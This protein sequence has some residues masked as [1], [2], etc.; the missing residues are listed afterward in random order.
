MNSE[1]I[2]RIWIDL[3][4]SP[5]VPLFKPIIE[6]LH[7]QGYETI[8]TARDFAQTKQLLNLYK[9][10][11]KII[12]KHGGKNKIKKVLNLILRALQLYFYMF[13]KK[14]DIALSHGSRSQLVATKILFIKSVLMLDYEY[15]EHI[16]FNNLATILL[17]PSI[18]PNNRLKAAGFNLKKVKR[19]NGFKEEIYLKDFVPNNYLRQSLHIPENSILVTIRPPGMV[20]N[21]H[22]SKSESIIEKIISKVL[23]VDNTYILIVNR[24]KEDEQLI[25]RKFGDQVHYLDVVVDGIQL[26]WNSDAFISGGGTMNREAALLGIPTYSIFTGQ[27]P[28]LDIFLSDEDKLIFVDSLDKVNNVSI[29]PRKIE[30]KYLPSNLDLTS[31]VVD[32]IISCE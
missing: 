9:I 14:V 22:N 8:I 26:I 10:N 5:H 11:G 7:K 17:I 31:E 4:N 27:K 18:I 24:T 29:K 6:E 19:Y 3:D 20:G 1:R 12:G 23:Q 16:I 21:Y 30:S 13:G 25:R 15:T 2:K 28:Y 32:I